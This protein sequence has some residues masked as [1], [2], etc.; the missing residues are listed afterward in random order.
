MLVFKS[1]IK[2][3]VIR[4]ITFPLVLILLLGNIGNAVSHAPIAVVDYAGSPAA[5]SFISALQS[6]HSLSIINITDEGTALSEISKGKAVLAVV[7]L[8]GFPGMAGRFPSLDLYYTS[9]QVTDS[10]VAIQAVESVASSFGAVTARDPAAATSPQPPTSAFLQMPLS[11]ASGSYKDFLIG[12]ILIMVAAFSSVFGGGMSIISDRALG[13]IKAFL[14]APINK[15]AIVLS[16]ILSGTTQSVF[17]GLIALAIGVADG[18]TIAMGFTG[19]LWVIVFIV[20]VALGFSG[21]TIL[22][23]S[24]INKVEVY[25]IIAQTITLPLWFLSGA[26]FPISSLPS[27][28]YPLSVVNPLTYAADGIRQVMMT[29]SFPMGIASFDV[30][31]MVVFSVVMLVLGFRMFKRTI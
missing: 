24:R 14:V 18:A 25:T 10:A 6:Q 1:K 13:N 5:L 27:W 28:I 7:I 15:N 8:P 12:G 21:L 11:G 26:F 30:G 17:S 2:T 3:N 16:R 29:G 9:S 4:S 22:I 19:I 20:F 31:V 23:A